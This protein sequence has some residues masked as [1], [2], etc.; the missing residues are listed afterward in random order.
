MIRPLIEGTRIGSGLLSLP[1]KL[2]SRQS[3]GGRSWLTRLRGTSFWRHQVKKRIAYLLRLITDWALFIL[4]VLTGGLVSAYTM[5]DNGNRLSTVTAGTW[6]MW[7]TAGRTDADPYTRAHYARLGALPLPAD[8]A[9]TWMARTDSAGSTLHSSCDY[10]VAVRPPESSWWSLAVFD[11][12]G[13]LIQNP[14]GRHVFTSDTGAISPDGRFIT[15]LSRSAGAGNWLPTGGAGNLS[16][17]YTLV[18]FSVAT[19]TGE[20]AEDPARRVPEII[21]KSCR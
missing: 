2:F 18:D 6:T 19:G 11:A 12:N 4:I 15:L 21:A 8:V 20:T 5:I 3:S 1:E 10:E 17:V 9:E 7:T 13:R 16:V 14:A